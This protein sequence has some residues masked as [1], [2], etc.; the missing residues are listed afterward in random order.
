MKDS[1]MILIGIACMIAVLS[2][3]REQIKLTRAKVEKE[4]NQTKKY[5]YDQVLDLAET[6]VASLNQTMVEP[7]KESETLEFDEKAKEKVLKDAKEKIKKDLDAK[8][9]ELLK[10]YLGSEENFDEYIDDAVHRRVHEAKK[11]K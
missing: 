1:F 9:K 2:F 4:E 5:V 11:K 7:L 3:V 6:I 8:S 10:E